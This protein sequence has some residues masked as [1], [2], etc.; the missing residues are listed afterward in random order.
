[1]DEQHSGWLN[2]ITGPAQDVLAGGVGGEI[3]ITDLTTNGDRAG[4][5]PRHFASLARFSQKTR[6][7]GWIGITDKKD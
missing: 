4:I 2:F 1:M 6:W 5:A 7:R 3:K